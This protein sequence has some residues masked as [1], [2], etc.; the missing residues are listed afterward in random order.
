MRAALHKAET[1]LQAIWEAVVVSETFEVFPS[2]DGFY[3]QQAGGGS[4]NW[5]TSST[6]PAQGKGVI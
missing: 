1:V 6:V 2:N 4:T 5:A 3:W